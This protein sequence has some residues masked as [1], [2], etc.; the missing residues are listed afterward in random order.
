MP[1]II[2]LNKVSLFLWGFSAVFSCWLGLELSLSPKSLSGN[3]SGCN[4]CFSISDIRSR[5]WLS[6]DLKFR[7]FFSSSFN[8]SQ[9]YS[10]SEGMYP[11]AMVSWTAPWCWGFYSWKC[12]ASSNGSCP[13]SS[14]YAIFLV[15]LLSSPK[16]IES[17]FGLAVSC[18]GWFCFIFISFFIIYNYI[19]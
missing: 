12:I 5:R 18:S 13:R 17:T 14:S 1:P 15:S 6:K 8:P 11:P 16:S 10:Y 2:D 4:R 9:S 3:L 7:P 19:Y